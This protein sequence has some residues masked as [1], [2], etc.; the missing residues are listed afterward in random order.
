MPHRLTARATRE[1]L[2]EWTSDEPMQAALAA[3]IRVLLLDGRLSA[4]SLLPAERELAAALR[5]SRTTVS[6][7]YRLLRE[8]GFARSRVGSGTTTA[9]P[10]SETPR[11]GDPRGLIDLTKA[12]FPATRLL[13]GALERA[14]LDLRP[15]LPTSGYDTYGLPSLRRAIADR[16]T[17]RGLPTGPGEILVTTGAQSA[18]AIAAR[19]LADRG[20]RVYAESPS[21]PHAYDALRSAGGRLITSPVSATDGWDLDA[22]EAA[23]RRSGPTLGYVMPD[24]HNPTG[25]NLSTAGRHRLLEA[26]S[27]A[28]TILLADDTTAELSIDR[29]I[30]HAPLAALAPASGATVVHIGSASKIFWGGLRIGWIRASEHLVDRLAAART[31]SDLASPVLEQLVVARLLEDVTEVLAERRLQLAEGR[32]TVAEAVRRHLPGWTMP[33]TLEGGL[34][35]WINLGA[36]V[37]SQL[38]FAARARGILITAGPRFGVDGAFETFLRVPIMQDPALLTHALR[39]FGEIWPTLDRLPRAAAESVSAV[40]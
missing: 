27:A 25:R 1:L 18:I 17:E 6:A 5:V 30:D 20:D 35:A 9:V 3:R 14:A 38:S 24:F 2:G 11:D 23:F 4:D 26:A 10:R 15:L 32:A 31:S 33:E 39:V 34:S 13:E 21:Y 12:S 8:T 29:V 40:A 7:A 36:P 37:S 19:V 28:G 22:L 16:Y